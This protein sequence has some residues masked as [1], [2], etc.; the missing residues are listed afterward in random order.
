MN[1]D[2]SW[3][4][5][6]SPGTANH[7]FQFPKQPSLIISSSE[8][9]LD[10]A[11]ILAEL[12]RMIYREDDVAYCAGK[13]IS[14][15]SALL[16]QVNIEWIDC[17]KNDELA[18]CSWLLKT[19][20][21]DKQN[22][23][24]RDCLILIF[25]GTNGFD[26]WKLNAKALH[27]DHEHGGS[28]HNGFYEAFRSIED[29]ILNSDD[30]KKLPVFLAGHSLGGAIATLTTATL[31]Q[32]KRMIDSCYTFGSPKV[33]DQE[34]SDQ[35]EGQNLYRLI[36]RNDIV[37]M[38]PFDFLNTHYVHAGESYYFTGEEY[39]IGKS[40][41]EIESIQ[42]SELPS[43][44]QVKSLDSFLNLFKSLEND[45]PSFLSDHAPINYL[46]RIDSFQNG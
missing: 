10:N 6:T 37:T 33:G 39:S 22:Q 26:N 38:L 24:N 30:L 7:Y 18:T 2:T 44:K 27:T 12:C 40:D 32:H 20:A 28:V 1:F 19:H 13:N 23:N 35:F 9:E 29:Q 5:L 34:F 3:E 41:S 16:Q 4:A 8:F 43:L 25:R 36:N 15:I 31:I 42:N 17:F 21:I 14:L 11:L 45:V 46:G